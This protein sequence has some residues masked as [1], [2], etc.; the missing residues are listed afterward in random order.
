[1]GDWIGLAFFVWLIAAIVVGL[2]LLSKPR[3]RTSDEY[4]RGVSEGTTMLGAWMN[5]LQEALDPAAAKA[6][7]V[8]MQMKDGRFMKK[9]RDGKANGEAGNS[10]EFEI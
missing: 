9:K 2:K 5:A 7:E 10:G 1:M 3:V 6:K 8:Q 4:E